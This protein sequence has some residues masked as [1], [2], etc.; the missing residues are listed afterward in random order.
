[1]IRYDLICDHDHRFEGW[2][3]GSADF[4]MQRD[5][6]QI[7]CVVCGSAKIDRAIMAPNVSTS[8]RQEK[9]ASDQAKRMKVVNDVANKIRKEIADNCD[10]VGTDFAEEARAIHYGEKP[11][12]GIYGQASPQEAAELVEEGVGVAALPDILA[13]KAKD[14]AN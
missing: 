14:K 3:S 5:K 12:R 6:G 8:R 2:F 11:E 7:E 13:P 4:E 10:N 1:M 9:I